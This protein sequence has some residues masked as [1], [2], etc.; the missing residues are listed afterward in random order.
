MTRRSVTSTRGGSRPSIGSSMSFDLLHSPDPVKPPSRPAA[1]VRDR[2]D[3]TMTSG[4]ASV[5]SA[6]AF[7]GVTATEALRD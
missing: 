2:R 3:R 7:H 4:T 5:P 6:P 1:D